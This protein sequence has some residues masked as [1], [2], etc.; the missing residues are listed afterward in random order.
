MKNKI[1]FCKAVIFDFDDTL[2]K[3]K[4]G[5]NLG[6]RLV[7]LKIY[8]FLKEKRV[9]IGSFKDFYRR[10]K[11]T[12]CKIEHR[13]VYDRN[14]WWF[15]I[16]KKLFKTIPPKSFLNKLTKIYWDAV[17]KKSELYQ[18]TLSTIV[19]LK[20]KKYI[21]GM[22][23]DTD[24]VKKLKSERIKKLNLKKWFNSIVIAGEDVKQTKPDKA[25][26]LLVAKKL[27][28][29]PQEC[30][31]VGNNLYLD[32]LGA[33]KVGMVTIL[34]KRDN[35]KARIKPDLVIYTLKELKK[36]L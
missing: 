5:K 32:I 27:D 22:V 24:G 8:L 2:A 21:L 29:N 26:F 9:N 13:R 23:T 31:F 30:I 7:S 3:T 1:N 28:L 36:V 17:K 19:Y 10:I 6:L 4:Y 16:T 20:N 15:F 25:P 14:F 12:I 18:D 11:K 35:C 34:I 33:K